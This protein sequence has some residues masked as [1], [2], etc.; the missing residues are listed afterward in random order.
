MPCCSIGLVLVDRKGEDREDHRGD[1]GAA[2]GEHHVGI[3]AGGVDDA[4]VHLVVAGV[5]AH[6]LDAAGDPDHAQ[7]GRVWVPITRF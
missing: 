6:R 2:A 5:A 4:A 7:R 1:R 3:I